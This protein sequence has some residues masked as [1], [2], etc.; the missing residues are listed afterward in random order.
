MHVEACLR[1]LAFVARIKRD[2]QLAECCGVQAEAGGEGEG[3]EGH[4]L[5]GGGVP[6]MVVVLGAREEGDVCCDCGRDFVDCAGGVECFVCS[7]RLGEGEVLFSFFL[8]YWII[9]IFI[10]FSRLEK[11]GR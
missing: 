2:C 1:Y 4:R 5:D 8:G 10:Y 7:S 11:K 9:F 6:W 3:F